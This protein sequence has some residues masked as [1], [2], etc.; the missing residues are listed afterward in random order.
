MRSEGAH[1]HEGAP[2]EAVVQNRG[3]RLAAVRLRHACLLLVHLWVSS[4]Q[5]VKHVHA[6]DGALIL[7][8]SHV[9]LRRARLLLVHLWIQVQRN[10]S[11]CHNACDRGGTTLIQQTL[12]EISAEALTP[13]AQSVLTPSTLHPS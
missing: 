4:A 8:Q 2:A 1:H 11:R 3:E 6:Y 5:P 7:Q 9:R 10:M 13:A 12:S